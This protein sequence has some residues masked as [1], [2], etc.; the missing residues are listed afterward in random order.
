MQLAMISMA[1][2]IA[3][4]GLLPALPAP[5]GLPVLV[6]ITVLL[7]AVAIAQ[8]RSHNPLLAPQMGR[9]RLYTVAAGFLLGLSW[10]LYS[11]Y[12]LLAKQLPAS[13]E[14]R[15]LWVQGTVV[16]LPERTARHGYNGQL[17]QVQRFDLQLE[18][19]TAGSSAELAPTAMERLRLN[20]YGYQ[21]LEPGQRWRLRVKLKKPRGLANPGGFNY[22]AWLISRG[23]S[24]S[25]YVRDPA[26]GVLLSEAVGGVDRLRF[27]A[28]A[29]IDQ[30]TKALLHRGIIKA[31]I[32]GDKRGID[33]QQWALFARTGTTHLMVI[34]GLHVGLLSV[35]GFYFGRNISLL[36]CRRW[37]ADR[38]GAITAITTAALYAAA[39]GFSLPT[40]RALVMI[41]VAMLVLLC[42]REM[43]ASGALLT[44]LLVCLIIDPLAAHSLSLWL[45]FGAVCA[46]FLGSSG[47]RTA[48]RNHASGRWAGSGRDR[49]QRA[50]LSQ[51]TVFI[52]MLPL[53]A[54][55]L[56]SVSALSPLANMV[57]V[58]LFTLLVVPLNM[59]A[60]LMLGFSLWLAD[61][62]GSVAESLWLLVDAMIGYGLQ[63][64]S[65][66]DRFSAAAFITV[67]AQPL[68]VML[69]AFVGAAVLLL[70]RGLGLR[71][72]APLLLLPLFLYRPAPLDHGDMRLTVIDVGQGL[73]VLVET[74]HHRLLYDTGP[75]AGQ[76]FSAAESAVIPL[77][78]YRGISALDSLILSHGD[79]DHAGGL[80]HLQ[81]Q[82][83]ITGVLYGE[84]VPGLPVMKRRCRR[85]HSWR[86]DAVVFELLSPM[87]STGRV[88]SNN[89]SCVLLISSGAV[90][91]L[92]SG[93]I[94]RRV[95][96]QL[97]NS[98]AI[99]L[100]AT[101]LVAPH[102]GSNSS[103]SMAFIEAV[104][105]QHV[106]FSSGYRNQFKHPTA[107]VVERYRR[108]GV[109]IHSTAEHGAVTFD[110]AGGQIV[111][112]AHFRDRYR[113]YWY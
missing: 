3:T 55:M 57:L 112:V 104:G 113:G 82:L 32:L 73:S 25:G 79:N 87:V 105:A 45:S 91:V 66:L 85:P 20:W 67:P 35:L 41:T 24:A 53:L 62:Q 56:G 39:A 90:R 68:A 4:V 18:A 30:H 47:R 8:H 59:L 97:V 17:Q 33:R 69:L 109:I 11:G 5:V 95:E 48:L 111:A 64:L 84:V 76:T 40:Q 46:I 60:A 6:L 65:W 14:G 89:R 9:L 110:V 37:A 42:R 15:E 44:A 70:P 75:S 7:A 102:H 98:D 22:Q 72:A 83:P 29:N 16:G 77:L 19:L 108:H 23:Y 51:S 58:P 80:A 49:L 36:L 13:L 1:A 88:S 96:Q 78:K 21:N 10:G 99:E 106:V 93:D 12:Q 101:V 74:R 103:S 107:Q 27:A 26:S 52:G 81:Q 38:A 2:G 86:W 54:L 100:A 31:L 92:L 63:L 28:A 50:W 34:S 94:E 71:A 61:G 43:G